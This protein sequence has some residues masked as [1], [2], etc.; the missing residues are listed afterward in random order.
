MTPHGLTG[1]AVTGE[2]LAQGSKSAATVC[3]LSLSE[4]VSKY[5]DGS[6]YEIDYG[7]VRLGC[8]QFQ[9]DALRVSTSVEG[10]QDGANRFLS[11][12][13]SK[14]LEINM[15]KSIYLLAGKKRNIERIRKEIE[16]NP[17]KYNGEPL[18]E[19]ECEKW[20]GDMINGKGN[21]QST[22]SSL[23]ERKNRIYN[24]IN[25]TIAILEDSRINRLGSM[26]CAIN[27][28]ELAIIPSLLNNSS[29]W[30]IRDKTIQTEL[31]KFQSYFFKAILQVPNSCPRPAFAYEANMLTMKYR[32]YTRLL[33]FLK[34]VHSHSDSNLSRLVLKEQLK[35]DWP[36]LSQVGMKIMDE[37]GITGL[38]EQKMRSLFKVKFNPIKR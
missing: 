5:Y 13:N 35:N 19:K 2:N 34:H 29:V 4:G 23:N 8:L 9:D 18:K 24:A 32:V 36:G 3:S 22:L 38:F 25:E 26:K 30:D 11:L 31:D 33:N 7:S 1:T 21:K 14:M 27:I 16:K 10:A 20:L 17:I 28:L 12:M 15:S 37:L 6:Q